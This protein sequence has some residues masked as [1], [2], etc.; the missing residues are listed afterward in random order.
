MKLY[1][2]TYNFGF[3]KRTRRGMMDADHGHGGGYDTTAAD[4]CPGGRP[5]GLHQSGGA[6]PVYGTAES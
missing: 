6:E 1:G 5:G 2:K 3:Q 4:M